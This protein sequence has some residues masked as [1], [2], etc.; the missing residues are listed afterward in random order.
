MNRASNQTADQGTLV[1][2]HLDGRELA[3]YEGQSLAA[4]L[5]AAGVRVYGRRV[6]GSPRGPYCNMGMCFECVLTVD[7]QPGVRA[8]LTPVKS[9][10]RVTSAMSTD[11]EQAMGHG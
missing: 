10:M 3:A 7:G 9:G 4:A 8:C 11:T 5:L 1:F 2:I 6:D